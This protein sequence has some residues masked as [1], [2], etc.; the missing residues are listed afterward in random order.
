MIIMEYNL[1]LFIMSTI[2][3]AIT[4]PEKILHIIDVFA[5]KKHISRSEFIAK[6]LD[7]NIKTILE[8]EVVESYNKVFDDDTIKKEQSA[9]SENLI[10]SQKIIDLWK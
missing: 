9:W 1:K 5:K 7:V 10:S 4:L 2:K 3:V 8:H 6:S